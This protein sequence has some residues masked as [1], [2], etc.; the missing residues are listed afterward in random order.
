MATTK[1]GNFLPA[2]FQSDANKKFLNA[3]LDQLVTE[4]NLKPVNGYIGRKFGPGQKSIESF[5]K[6]PTADRADYQLEPSIVVKN[7]TTGNIEFNA[8]YP[9]VLQQ[10]GFYGGKINNHD[11]LWSSEYYSYN[12]HINYDAFVNFSQYYWIPNG[13]DSVDVFAGSVDLQK[14]Y[15]VYP[16][17]NTNVYNISGYSTIANPEIILA[18]GGTYKFNVNQYGKPFY[19]QTDPGTSGVQTAHSNFSSRQVLGVSNNGDDVGVVTFTV[20]S[21]TAQDFYVNMPLVQNVDLVT[22][23]MYSQIQGQSLSIFNSTYNGIDGQTYLNGKYLI[24]GVEY[25]DTASW[26]VGTTVP[27]NQRYGVWQIS[28]TGGTINLSYVTSIPVN[29]K[30]VITT[31]VLYASTTWYTDSTNTL[32]QAPIVTANLDTLYYQDGSNSGQY[33]IIKLIDPSNNV[34]NIDT[35]VLGKQNYVS[36]NGVTFTNGLKVKFDTSVLPIDY[37]DKEWYVDGVGTD[38]GISLTSVDSLAISYPGYTTNYN[39]TTWFANANT[40]GAPVY[41]KLNAAKDQITI[42]TSDIPDGTNILYGT[43]PNSNNANYVVQQDITL[44]YPYRAG[45]NTQGTHLSNILESGI[46]GITL[47]GIVIYGPSNDWY[48]PGTNG[49]NWHYDASQVLINGEDAYSGSPDEAGTYHYRDSK[50]ITANAWGNFG[51]FTSNLNGYLSTDNSG[52]SKLI[53]WA[54]DGYPIYG[55]FGY[56]N[57]SNPLSGAV[58]MT[59]SYAADNNGYGRPIKQTVTVSANASS[60]NTITVSSTFGLNPG[61]RVT[62]NT[63]GLPNSGVWILN[64]GLHSAV[65]PDQFTQGIN[66]IQLNTNV[67]ILAGT[68]IDFEFLPGAFIEDYFYTGTGTLDRF[69]GRYGVTPEFPAGTY[70]YFASQDYGSNPVYPYF[71]GSAFYGSLSIDTSSSLADKDYITINRSSRDINL[72]SKHNRWFHKD[73]IDATSRYNNTVAVFDQA[74]R[75]N[76]PIIE[77]NPNYQLYDFGRTGL[78]PVDLF[79]NTITTPFLTVEGQEG[80]YIDGVKVIDGMR[81][82]F[83]ADQDPETVHKI[84]IANFY[85]Q[86]GN[87]PND[88]TVIHLHL[89]KPTDHDVQAGDTITVLS[90]LTSAGKS[91]WYDGAQWKT[92]QTRTANNQAPTFDVFDST[93]TSLGDTA[94][95]PIANNSQAFA[96]TKIFSY[97]QGTGTTDSVLGFPLSYRNFNNVGDIEFE[98]NFDNDTFVYTVNGVTYNDKINLGFLY[99]NNSDGSVKKLNVWSTVTENTKQYQ[100]IAYVYDGIDNSFTLDVTPA[101]SQYSHSLLVFVNYKKISASNYQIYN[102]PNNSKLVSIN[103]AKLKI[104]DRVDFLVYS[105]SVSKL[106]YYQIPDNLN[107]NAKNSPFVYPTL[108]EIRNHVGKLVDGSLPFVGSYPGPSN[109]R[110][111]TITNQGGTIVQQSA[112]TSYASMFLC[113][114]NYNFVNSLTSASQEYTRF[115]NKFLTIASGTNAINYT[116]PASAVDVILEQINISKNKL[117]PWYYSDMIPYGANKNTISYNIFDPAQRNYEITNLFT[118]TELSNQAI[119]VYVNGVQLTYGKDYTFLTQAPGISFTSTYTPNVGDM[120]T[121]VEYYDT[122]GCYVPETPS[123]L[124]L[125]PKYRP[126]IVTDYTYIK[127]QTFIVGHD[128]SLTPT[129][130]DFRDDLILELEKRIFNNIKANY[131]PALLNIY[132]NIPGKFRDIGYN[133]TEYNAVLTKTYLQW[134]GQNNLD[135]ITNSTYQAG[136]PFTYNYG[137]AL[138]VVNGDKLP[139]SWR[140]CFEYFYDTTQPHTHPWE[141]LGFSEKPSWWETYYGPAPYTGGNKVL[142]TDLANGYIRDGDRQGFDVRF[143][144]PGLLNIIPVNENGELLAPIGLLTQ[145][146]DLNT[147]DNNWQV[148]QYSPTETAWRNSSDYPFALQYISALIHPAKYF[149]LG[150]ATS[151]YKYNTDLNQYLV[152]T[153]NQRLTPADIDINGYTSTAGVTSRNSSYINWISDYLTSK[154]ITDKTDLLNYVRNYTVQ[155]SYR[156]AGFSG[157][158]YFKVLAEQNSPN[159]TNESILIPDADINLVLNKSTPSNN[160]RYSA[161][162]IEKRTDGWQVSGYDNTHPY[163]V[164]VPPVITGTSITVTTVGKSVQYYEEFVDYKVIIPY[165][166]TFTSYQQVASF[167]AGYERYQI[168]SGFMFDRYDPDL[169]QI[170]NWELS[171]KEFLFWGQQGWAVNSILVLN[172]AGEKIKFRSTDSVVDAITNSFYGSKVMTENY[173]VLDSD[174]YSV[175]RQDNNFTISIDPKNGNMIGLLDIQTVQYEHVLIFEN[176]TQFN[177]IIYDPTVGQRQFKLKLIGSKTAGWTGTLAPPGFIYNKEGVETWMPVTDY[178]KGDL[179]EYKNFYYAA[180]KNLPGAEEF[181]FNNWLPV[182]KSKIKTGLLSNFARNSSLG[183]NFYNVDKVNLESEFD[184]F[185]L[186]L[187]GYRNRPYLN[188]LALDDVTQVKFYQG[189]IKEK[190][191]LNAIDALGRVQLGPDQTSY[192]ISEDWAFRVGAYGSLDTNQFVEL[193]LDEHYVLNNPTSLEVVDNHTVVYSSLYQEDFEI[194]KT[195]DSAWS[196]PFLL[197]RTG[198]SSYIEDLK[199]AGFVNIDDVDYTVFDLSNLSTLSANIA[200]ISVGSTIWTAVDYNQ[201]WNVFRVNDTNRNIV[202]IANALDNKLQFTTDLNHD[203][204]VDDI[205]VVTGY[206]TYSGFYRIS[207]VPSLTAVVADYVGSLTGFSKI[208]GF[209][210]MHKLVSVRF[211]YASQISSYT[212]ANGWSV[213]NKAWINQGTDSKWAVYN[214]S[215][216]WEF[217][218]RL[219]QSQSDANV[220]Y[221]SSVKISTDGTFALIGQP[222]YSANTGAVTTM[223]QS[224]TGDFYEGSTT[225]TLAANAK[226]MGSSIDFGL[227]NV[228]VGA[229]TSSSNIGYVVGFTKD[230]TGTL[231]T[232]QILTANVAGANFGTS[233]SL[234][235]DEQWLYVGAPGVG[236]VYVYAYDS[237]VTAL[238]YTIAPANAVTKTFTLGFTPSSQEFLY[239]ARSTRDYVPN[240]DFTISGNTITFAANTG[241]GNIVVRQNPGYRYITSIAHANASS[242]FGYSVASSTDG[243]QVVIGA[244]LANIVV[245]NTSGIYGS[246]SVYDRSVENFIAGTNQTIFTAKRSLLSVSKVYVD[247]T[248]QVLGVDYVVTLGNQV[249]FIKIPPTGAIISIETDQFNKIQEYA[250]TTSYSNQQFGYS[251]D[252]CPRNC[253]LYAGAPYQSSTGVYNGAVYRL[254]NQGKVYGNVICSNVL[255]Q[256]TTISTDVT[257]PNANVTANITVSSITNL[258]VGMYLIQSGTGNINTGKNYTISAINTT[259]NVVTLSANVTGNVYAGTN[260]T[261]AKIK[262]GDSIRINNFEVSFLDTRLSY[263][264]SAINS[265]NIPGVAAIGIDGKLALISD[266]RLAFDKLNLLPGVGT[267]LTDIGANVFVQTQ[268]IVND[269]NHSYDYFG[270]KV[271]VNNNSDVLFVGSDIANTLEPTTFD[272]TSTTTYEVTFDGTSTKFKDY[273]QTSGSVW[274][275]SYLPDSRNSIYYPGA[276]NFVERLTPYPGLKTQVGFGHDIDVNS[277]NLIVGAY[278]DSTYNTNTGIVY[279]FKNTNALN[280]WDIVQSEEP[281]VDINCLLKNYVYSAS[282]QTILYN[283]DYID[284][285]KGKILGVAEQDI[286]YKTDYDPAIYNVANATTVSSSTSL[287]WNDTQVGQVWWD[288]STVRFVDYEQGSIKYRTTNWG[289]TFPGSSID[290]YEWVESIYP[291]SQYVAKGGDGEPKYTQNIAYSTSIYV[292]PNTNIPVVKYYYWV[293]NKISVTPNQ[294]GREIPTVTIADYISNP[295]SSGIKYLAALRDDSVAVYNLNKNVTGKD[296]ILHI[297]Y[298]TQINDN[299][300]HSEYALVPEKGGKASDI[301]NNIYNKLLD[302]VSGLDYAGNPVP[303]PKLPIQ[304][305]YGIDIR[306]RQ[307]MFVDRLQAVKEMV[308]YVNTIFSENIISQGF[309]LTTLSSGEP[310]PTAGT[311]VFD[312]SVNT[313]EELTY[314]DIIT[315]PTGYR[316]L[317]VADSTVDNL[318]SIYTKQSTNTWLLTR[319]Q[320]Y[321]TPDYWKYVDWYAPGFDKTTRPKYIVNTYS[322]LSSLPL[323]AQDVVK[324]LNNGQGNWLLLQVFPDIVA[325]VGIQSGTIELTENL[326]NL[327]DYGMGYG[328]DNFDTQRFD[329][330]PSIELRNILLALRNDLFINQLRENFLE[331]FYVFIYYVLDEQKYVDWV[332]KTSFI[333]VLHKFRGLNQPQIYNKDN[334][335]YYKQY[336]EEVKPYKTTI[337]EYVLDYQGTDNLTGYVTDFDVPPFY[338]KV[339]GLY[340]SPSGTFIQDATQLQSPQY[341]DWLLTYEYYIDSISI[342]NGGSGYTQAPVVTIT[343]SSIGNNAVARALITNGVVSKIEVL[344]G[345]SNYITQP[346]ITLSGGNGTGAIAYAQLVN[347]TVRKTKT[348]LVYDRITYDTSVL[349]WT[350]N[351]SYTTG[352]IISYNGVGYVV[353]SNFT[354]G[355]TFNGNYLTVYPAYKFNNANDRIQAYYNPS[356]GQVGKQPSLLQSGIN[357]PGVVVDGLLFTDTGGFGVAGFD[358]SPFDPY[359]IDAEGN[360]V[361]SDSILDSVIQSS[362]TD[363]SLGIRPE[364]IIIDG[365]EYVDTYSSHAPEELVPGRVFD[366]LD[367]TITTFATNAASSSYTSWVSSNG[368]EVGSIEVVDEGTGYTANTISVTISG[369]TGS[370]A[371]VTPVLDSNGSIMSMSVV[372]SGTQ[373]TTIPNVIITGSNTSPAIAT[374]ILT[375]ND[376]STF[377]YKIFKDMN[378]NYGYYRVSANASTTIVSTT[379]NTITVANSSVLSQPNL[380]GAIPGVIFVNGERITYWTNNVST[381]TLSNIRRATLGTGVSTLATG[382]E[383]YDESMTQ[384]VPYSDN[385]TWTP[386]IDTTKQLTSTGYATFKAG[387]TYIRSN[388]W[389]D[390]GFGVSTLAIEAGLFTAETLL[391]TETPEIMTTEPTYASPSNGLGLYVS[392]LEPAIFVRE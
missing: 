228:L 204:S 80:L 362:Y 319:V 85:D 171:T 37:Q 192:T 332:F 108:G 351:T 7:S 184:L 48:V 325:T 254:L 56:A 62:N 79:D 190:G 164:I 101:L 321:R 289:R 73:V 272:A 306:P 138:D 27:T 390:P 89:E 223:L 3:T 174:A 253:S 373:Y 144:R 130:G 314:I 55:P 163:F 88:P 301:P 310:I 201:D 15:Y 238:S 78:E 179:V 147:L 363:T 47:P 274:T 316:V 151:K 235:D 148:G 305:R 348:T 57:P 157:K 216:P 355:S 95:Y 257:A 31:G 222:G 188:D 6:E 382:N 345:G 32:I 123:K 209:Y 328:N 263:I 199:S 156:M 181:N 271:K 261:F 315:Q 313:Y 255:E 63:A 218:K 133:L 252:L 64:C 350:A 343:G 68:S 346:V 327:I 269:D 385:Y 341:R 380:E 150:I 22:T 367:I 285:L 262:S 83:A 96:G 134:V 195:S 279:Q 214:K 177:D 113:D 127:P 159:S 237:S 331:L 60:T 92:G 162:I 158:Q 245:G 211:D 170:R 267:A 227:T 369:T 21:K 58:R 349:D 326:Y 169:G 292:D 330:N 106:G 366:T 284:P 239:V 52:H 296:V 194:Y 288:L 152:S 40:S 365:G 11:R 357:Y 84:W 9:E 250:P 187:I 116:N 186:G 90:G 49:T 302:S 283:L 131:D 264:I 389:L 215:E 143:A 129:F 242:Q 277:Y 160:P 334:Q 206:K 276:F 358:S 74:A 121:I 270:K 364:D 51:Y 12:P 372:S 104:N 166:T 383:V 368:F 132:D 20:P 82:I 354:S 299:I 65:G 30:V 208:T 172:P 303:D 19:I 352:T 230:F 259:S 13:P 161:V 109:I 140:A 377:S 336:I 370:S 225:S 33:G 371:T 114:N 361:I 342:Q 324:V 344:Y 61:M 391:A 69:N 145:K 128:G 197:N 251:V 338:D 34:I 196:P 36:P 320:Q 244:P 241:L 381:N 5:I 317:V 295:K 335:E 375:Q 54:A 23:L 115:K 93:G 76:R 124:G 119:L 234:S 379:A 224:Y 81:I 386:N 178:L 135:Y 308:T 229:P 240:V 203:L 260:L 312:L 268:R 4:P 50:F 146:Y 265:T 165:G 221:G 17:N 126:E 322:D 191:T 258:A 87:S 43:F 198:E 266:S 1:T 18:R 112:P 99:K 183:K 110:D 59:S 35:E 275:F 94:K 53:G 175:V 167:L 353:N 388:L 86:V 387:Q 118:N 340:R 173:V 232:N 46:I 392:S 220:N 236:K 45:Q 125:Y 103:P 75:A 142:W 356:I 107:L 347:E 180:N 41:A 136:V 111:I 137:L 278:T 291:P 98:N 25:T 122:D 141:M 309:D 246:V 168:N 300:I 318:W 286:T 210:P 26:T 249:T 337:R 102:I 155:L 294:F 189:F 243:A 298:A 282:A 233:I 193:V 231:T 28:T 72:W 200:D 248:L 91:Y 202:E 297:D 219:P 376:Y 70:A 374:A 213:N 8:T 42:S 333:N 287:H 182:D 16:D 280:G 359:D 339:L 105:D 290:V 24:F 2:V 117:F 154:G 247:K 100:D 29:N 10:I 360:P 139:G 281:R 256:S 304:N 44:N 212:P 207:Y 185:S 205:I 293:K 71:V 14:T 378:D 77:F 307:S 176:T 273:I 217:L 67:S 329:Q 384:L 153:T 66:Q 149:A 39:P 323:K 38:D 97:K 311:D 120:L 226:G